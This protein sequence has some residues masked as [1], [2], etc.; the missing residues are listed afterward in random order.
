MSVCSDAIKY[1]QTGYAYIYGHY[2]MRPRWDGD[3]YLVRSGQHHPHDPDGF[4]TNLARLQTEA[5]A[6]AFAKKLYQT[7]LEQ[8]LSNLRV[9]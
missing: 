7:Y 5:E 6:I 1:D 8:E 2:I 9:K 3:G 4:N